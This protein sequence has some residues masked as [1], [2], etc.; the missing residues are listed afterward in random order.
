MANPIGFFD[1]HAQLAGARARK[2]EAASVAP[3][4]TLS[5]SQ[6]TAKIDGALKSG[7]PASLAVQGEIS[8]WNPNR[9][10]GHCYFTLK[11]PG[12]CIDC[13]MFRSD[14][15]R[16]KFKPNDG[17]EI[18]AGGRVGVYPQRGRYQLYV[19]TINPVGQG[20]L[21]LAF[22]QLKTK[23]EAEG[24]FDPEHK[25]PIPRFPRRLVLVTS[26]GT[27]ALQDM[28]KV[29]R[30]FPWVRL[31][32]YHVPVQ[33][34]GCG[35]KIAAALEHLNETVAR[36]GTADAI[37]LA[38]G[39]GS[40][41]DLWGFNEECV[42]QAVFNSILPVITGIGHEV[43]VSIADLVAD[44]HA[45][46]PTEAAQV[47]TQHWR[48]ARDAVEPSM[49]RLRRSIAQVVSDAQ[50]RLANLQRHE[51]FRRPTDRIN[52]FRQRL[53][54]VD[55]QLL[56]NTQRR[57]KAMEDRLSRFDLQLTEHSPRHILGL[58]RMRMLSLDAAFSRAAS[59][60]FRRRRY[61]LECTA[62]KLEA[63]SPEAVLKRGYSLTLRKKDGRIIRAAE[64]LKPGDRIITR[65]DGGQI[66]STVEDPHQPKLFE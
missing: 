28:F 5:V 24:L 9:Q 2:Q 32:V 64:D 16:L 43:D 31:A 35:Q 47:V 41:E 40:L 21:E 39:G 20:A 60:A 17:L 6:I 11:D 53:D 10:S 8:N 50:S 25:R 57:I 36:R 34:D 65:L 56:F 61:E 13:V 58:H 42:A 15:E 62:A 51:F 18:I 38:R 59:E 23:L 55:R 7:L 63:L 22:Q 37:I 4:D 29:L 52:L 44:Y 66:E 3:R 46:T 27:A 54:D 49:I 12:A 19:S 33:G 48:N 14:A 30:R 26:T 1:M 45:H